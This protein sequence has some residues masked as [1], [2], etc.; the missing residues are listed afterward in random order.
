[1]LTEQAPLPEKVKP[2]ES[3]ESV[4]ERLEKSFGK[5][6][7]VVKGI[8]ELKSNNSTRVIVVEVKSGSICA[9]FIQCMLYMLRTSELN[10]L[11]RPDLRNKKPFDPDLPEGLVIYVI[12]GIC[13]N[14]RLMYMISFDGHSFKMI[15]H[16]KV[17]VEE[18]LKLFK[19]TLT[20]QLPNRDIVHY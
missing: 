13:S 14:G 20:V 15:K 19:D 10:L 2:Y 11:L 12:Y 8:D 9:A 4:I 18:Q 6:A 5:I 3:P 1:M 7:F 17:Q 16:P